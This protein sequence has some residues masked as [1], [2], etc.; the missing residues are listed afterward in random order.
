MCMSCY[1]CYQPSLR[2]RLCILVLWKPTAD[3]DIVPTLPSPLLAQWCADIPRCNCQNREER[4][5]SMWE[6]REEKPQG[7]PL[8]SGSGRASLGMLP[9]HGEKTV[10]SCLR[11]RFWIF[12]WH[13][14]FRVSY[15]GSWARAERLSKPSGWGLFW[16][17]RGILAFKRK[18]LKLNNIKSMSKVE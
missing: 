2:C 6:P 8:W 16:T 1:P 14:F 10:G 18:Y 9:E 12:Y 4:G 15:P 7:V 3:S 5:R 13:E 17:A 11:S